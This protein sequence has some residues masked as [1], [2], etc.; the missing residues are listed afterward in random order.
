MVFLVFLN[1][2]LTRISRI[3]TNDNKLMFNALAMQWHQQTAL[4]TSLILAKFVV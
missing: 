2:S 1:V 4:S 3:D